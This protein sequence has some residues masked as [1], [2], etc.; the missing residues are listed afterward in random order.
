MNGAELTEI[1]KVFTETVM[2]PSSYKQQCLLNNLCLCIFLKL[3]FYLE[4]QEPTHD[5]EEYL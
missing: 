1:Q 5:V 3:A 4:V 2:Q